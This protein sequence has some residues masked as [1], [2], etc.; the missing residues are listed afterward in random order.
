[1]PLSP[2]ELYTH[3]HTHT[4]SLR[5]GMLLGEMLNIFIEKLLH[6]QSSRK[7]TC[8]TSP[9]LFVLFFSFFPL[10][11]SLFLLIIA[12]N[13]PGGKQT[14]QRFALSTLTLPS[15]PPSLTLSLYT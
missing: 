11:F 10:F 1:V 2:P 12:W 6:L 5:C 15:L 3:T 8:N 14:H 9:R 13:S 4:H 7:Q